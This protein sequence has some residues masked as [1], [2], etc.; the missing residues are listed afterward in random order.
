M[1]AVSASMKDEL[2]FRTNLNLLRT[3]YHGPFEFEIYD[4]EGTELIVS[5]CGIGKVNAAA[6][7]QTLILIYKPELIVNIGTAGS[8]RDDVKRKDVVIAEETVQHDF[9]LQPFGYRR[10]EIAELKMIEIPCDEKFIK[11]AEKHTAEYRAH[12][13]RILS[14]DQVIADPETVNSITS[15][16]GGL[17]ADM[18]SAAF[19]Q[20]CRLNSVPF[21]A[22]R[23]I[24]DD[25]DDD[26][27]ADFTANIGT[28][29]ETNG[30][31][32]LSILHD[33][34]NS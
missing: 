12:F 33:Y 16:F 22:L 7:A 15:L 13:G 34:I 1:I 3:E 27:F 10:G 9:N 30:R 29:S 21:A 17:S 25:G 23:G 11:T 8:V 18:E 20:V 19:A 14:G 2:S 24:S 32:L 6:M 4:F 26:R 28:V 5:V 31:L